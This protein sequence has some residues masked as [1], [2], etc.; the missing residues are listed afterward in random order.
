[1]M[2]YFKQLAMIFL[3]F[4]SPFSVPAIATT[5]GFAADSARDMLRGS[6]DNENENRDQSSKWGASNREMH[7]EAVP[8]AKPLS[9]I[10]ESS[11]ASE[12][13]RAPASMR[14]PATVNPSAQKSKKPLPTAKTMVR[15]LKQKKAFQEAAVIVNDLGFFPST[16]FVTQGIPVR[17]YVTGASQKSQCMILDAYG[18]RRQIRNQKVEEVTF[19]PEEVGKFSFTC[20]MNGAKGTIIVK[21]LQINDRLP[22][23]EPVTTSMAKPESV[24]SEQVDADSIIQDSDFGTEFRLK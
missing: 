14:E 17:L 13:N 18:I 21:E 19:T 15:T 2:N 23:S 4:G 22:A 24:E 11:F 3:I 16:L 6:E 8:A 9:A 1:M 12:T 20:P 7:A 10:D 5:G